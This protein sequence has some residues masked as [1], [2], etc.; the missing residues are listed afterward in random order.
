MRH[1]RGFVSGVDF[2][3]RTI[4]FVNVSNSNSPA[5]MHPHSGVTSLHSKIE[6]NKTNDF[7]PSSS[8]DSESLSYTALVLAVGKPLAL[9]SKSILFTT[10]IRKTK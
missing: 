4:Q 9:S 2:D 8:M 10:K 7:I 1:V 3:S 6:E 5:G